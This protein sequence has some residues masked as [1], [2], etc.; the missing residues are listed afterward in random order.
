MKELNF[1][2]FIHK[3]AALTLCILVLCVAFIPSTHVDA[4]VVHSSM[5]SR[6]FHGIIFLYSHG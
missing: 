3:I 2:F 4:L 6:L 1:F 5:C